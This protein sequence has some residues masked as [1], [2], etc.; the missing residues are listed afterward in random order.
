MRVCLD[1][2]REVLFKHLDEE[3]ADLLGENL[4]K[5]WTLEVVERIM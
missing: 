1:S 3:V 5:Y 4:R 2:F